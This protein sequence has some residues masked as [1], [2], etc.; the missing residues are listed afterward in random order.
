MK[1]EKCRHDSWKSGT[2]GISLRYVSSAVS[3]DEDRHLRSLA[4][5]L[6]GLDE[7]ISPERLRRVLAA[8]KEG[9]MVDQSS[10]SL[11]RHSPS[12]LTLGP[13]HR[14][15]ARDQGGKLPAHCVDPVG[16]FLLRGHR[17]L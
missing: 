8:S 4:A 10:P 11:H 17:F 16:Q 13:T 9:S 2:G 15:R 1:N 7:R 12:R 6:W 14:S 5:N 3:L